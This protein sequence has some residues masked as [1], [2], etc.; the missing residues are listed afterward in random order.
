[1][2]ASIDRVAITDFIRRYSGDFKVSTVS[3][4]TQYFCDQVTTVHDNEVSQYS[5]SA[6]FVESITQSLM[7]LVE[8]G[9]SHTV[10]DEI[11]IHPLRD[12]SIFISANY[13]RL[14]TAG[15]LFAKVGASYVVIQDDGEFKIA[16]ILGQDLDNLIR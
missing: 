8:E 10:L 2:N 6:E 5:S 11:H 15:G 14:N 7:P 12:N 3:G 16:V 4:M 1:M 13:S 9:F